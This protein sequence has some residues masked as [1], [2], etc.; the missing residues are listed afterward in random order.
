M[1]EGLNMKKRLYIAYGS[2]LHIMQMKHRCPTATVVG[3]S[4]LVGYKLIFKG[5]PTNAYATIEESTHDTV[6]VLIW[7]LKPQD[8]KA[9]DRYEGYPT[10]YYKENI[11]VEFEGKEVQAMV[12]IMNKKSQIGIPSPR[13]YGIIRTGYK[14]A[15]FDESILE[16]AFN[17]SKEYTNINR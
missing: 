14:T 13:Y 8:E 11:S 6:P 15:E 10:F 4:E 16:N 3:K 1:K 7:E 5:A 2:N 12:Y 17:I 9:L